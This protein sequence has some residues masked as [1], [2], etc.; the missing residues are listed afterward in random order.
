[1]SVADTVLPGSVK[2]AAWVYKIVPWSTQEAARDNR[3]GETIHSE[4]TIK[5]DAG[6]GD[7]QAAVTLLHEILHAIWREW[8]IDEQSKQE[9]IVSTLESGLASV[10]HDNPEVMHWILERTRL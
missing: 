1:V 7:K 3:W 9:S 6:W 4:H 2:V 10:F 8:N 5:I